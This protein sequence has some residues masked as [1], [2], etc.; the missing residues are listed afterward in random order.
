MNS[1]TITVMKYS[2]PSPRYRPTSWDGYLDLTINNPTRSQISALLYYPIDT[3]NSL[4]V[5]DIL[6]H[7]RPLLNRIVFLTCSGLFG[8]YHHTSLRTQSF[9]HC[10]IIIVEV[11]AIVVIVI[12][13]VVAQ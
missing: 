12:V 11:M 1:M 2:H 3:S 13:S 8:V 7:A 9:Y 5:S 6:T 10:S 4:T